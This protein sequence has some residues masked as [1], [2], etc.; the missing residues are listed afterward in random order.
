MREPAKASV[1]LQ[2]R[3]GA[4]LRPQNI[5]AITNLIANAVE[6][7]TPDAVSVL[8]MQG[9]LLSRPP[10]K[11]GEEAEISQEN[12]AYRQ[13]L[14]KDL[15]AKVESTLEPLLGP[16]KFRVGL[17]VDCDFSSAEQSDEVLDPTHSVMVSSQKSEDQSNSTP[18]AGIPGT[19]S[20]LPRAAARPLGA[21]INSSRRTENVSYE[22]SKSIKRTKTPQGSIKRISASLLLDQEVQWEGKGRDRHRITVPPSAE[23]LKAINEIVVG[24]LG[25]VPERGDHLVVQSL[26]F[27]QT[28]AETA[29]EESAP[30][31]GN[32]PASSNEQL[33]HMLKDRRVL[34]GTGAAIVLLAAAFAFFFLRHRKRRVEL[35]D[36]P[37]A[38][39][40]AEATPAA[41]DAAQ[42]AD[43]HEQ[44][45]LPETEQIEKLRL[46]LKAHIRKEPEL[47]AEI[48]RTWLSE[49]NRPA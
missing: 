36:V 30:K 10:R 9:N 18:N 43:Q 37:A 1:L 47:A 49:G 23:K 26:A 17:S 46:G 14:E 22:T 15:A 24:V 12:L 40:S 34:M 8:D 27:E 32:P 19:P 42:A 33:N 13:Q 25:I 4:Q 6:G 2:T 35:A 20:N 16:G 45:L 7:L 38:I 48:I 29:A 39:Q 28:L 5:V 3:P 31:S 21:G 44:K 41:L 11:H